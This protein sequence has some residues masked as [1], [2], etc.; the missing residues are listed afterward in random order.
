MKITGKD[1][2]VSIIEYDML[3][4]VIFED[5]RQ[6]GLYTLAEAAEK[7]DVGIESIKVM[8]L[9]GKLVSIKFKDTTLVNIPDNK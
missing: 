5:A 3:N 1:L 7:L 6:I 4:Q 9:T 2:V 8:I